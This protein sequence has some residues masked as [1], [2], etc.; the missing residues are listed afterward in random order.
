ILGF[1]PETGGRGEGGKCTGNARRCESHPIEGSPPMSNV[2]FFHG[3]LD[4]YFARVPQWRIVSQE[5]KYAH[6]VQHARRL[7]YKFSGHTHPYA[8]L[9]MSELIGKDIDGLERLDTDVDLRRT[10]FLKDYA[11]NRV[12]ERVDPALCGSD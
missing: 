10:Y 1:R 7:V 4:T 5:R 12:I 6:S 11:P 2:R 8:Q 9:L 3:A